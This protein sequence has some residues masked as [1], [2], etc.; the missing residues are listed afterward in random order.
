[1][2]ITLTF[3]VFLI[4][5][6]GSF[7]QGKTPE[8]YGLNHYSIQNSKLGTINF[9]VTQKSIDKEKPLLIFLD[10]SGNLPLYSVLQ[11]SDGTSQIM[12]SVPSNFY[13][14][15]DKFHFVVI[16]KPGVPFI[17]SLKA[18]SSEKFAE[19]YTPSKEYIER[20]SLEWRVNS[21]SLVIDYLNKKLPIKDNEIFAV[22]YSEGGQVVPKLA[23][24]NKKVT[25]IVNIV[26]GGLNQFFDFITASRLKAQK[27]AITQEQAQKEI[28]SLTSVFK[29]IY[30]HPTATDKFWYGHTYKRWASFC[31]DIPLNNMLQLNIP[32]LIIAGAY[33]KNS[34]ITGID[35]VQLEFTRQQKQNLTYKVYPNCDHWFNDQELKDNRFSDMINYVAN[36]LTE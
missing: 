12:S 26:G 35:Y 4:V 24:T 33:D 3:L 22:G 15:A 28:D 34:P 18:D 7:G 10:G 23:L 16:S 32:I 9:Y 17:D 14:L 21:A 20:L 6:P 31:L 8:E 5:N 36:W 19:K 11:K 13:R 2:R 29:D 25:R 30:A 1:M 27:G